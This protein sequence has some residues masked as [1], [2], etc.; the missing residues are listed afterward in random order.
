MSFNG[1]EVMKKEEKKER[2]KAPYEKPV[3]TKFK[4][5][6]DAVALATPHPE[7]GCTRF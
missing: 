5:L 2:E 1:G 7:L 3:L 6:T 4:K